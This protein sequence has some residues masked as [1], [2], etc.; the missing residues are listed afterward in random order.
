M[1]LSP[2]LLDYQWVPTFACEM[3]GHIQSAGE[4]SFRVRRLVCSDVGHE[5]QCIER[6]ATVRGKL[7]EGRMG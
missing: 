4:A 3:C 5:E 1:T 7:V 2:E 6:L